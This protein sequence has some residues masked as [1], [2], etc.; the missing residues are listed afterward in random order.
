MYITALVLYIA[1]A[2]EAFQALNLA[3]FSNLTD[4]FIDAKSGIA[5]LLC[6]SQLNSIV[7]LVKYTTQLGLIGL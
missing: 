6:R 5:D 3:R 4:F 7:A 2:T 1:F